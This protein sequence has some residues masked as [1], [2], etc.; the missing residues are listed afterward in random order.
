MRVLLA[1]AF[2]AGCHAGDFLVPDWGVPDGACPGPWTEEV[3][4]S[5]VVAVTRDAC[6]FPDAAIDY[7]L[8]WRGVRFA[9]G[10]METK[11]WRFAVGDGSEL[12]LYD[13][14]C[15]VGAQVACV[16]CGADLGPCTP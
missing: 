15:T 7:R 9:E 4:A 6:G 13:Q 1:A 8:Y 10:G 14:R 11:R 5:G 2:L 12:R 3:L 16:A